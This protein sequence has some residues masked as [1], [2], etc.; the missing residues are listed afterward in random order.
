MIQSGFAFH[1]PRLHSWSGLSLGTSA[2][3]EGSGSHPVKLN[4]S[5]SLLAVFDS[6]LPHAAPASDSL[7]LMRVE[8]PGSCMVMP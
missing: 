4:R 1:V 6:Q 7:T 3:T 8:T 5:N 2:R